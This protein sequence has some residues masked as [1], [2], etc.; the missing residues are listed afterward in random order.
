MTKDYK[1]VTSLQLTSKR[2]TVISDYDMI[3]RQMAKLTELN[4]GGNK[5]KSIEKLTDLKNLRTL[6]L[7]DNLI[8]EFNNLNLPLLQYLIV[9]RNQISTIN[10]LSS[11]KKLQ[12]LSLSGN[13]IT[14]ASLKDTTYLLVNL[15]YLNLSD[16]MIDRLEFLYGYPK[17]VEFNI[18]NNPIDKIG[19]NTFRE[20]VDLEVLQLRNI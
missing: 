8:T 7:S 19:A 18:S 6:N 5:I 12:Y 16:N 11:V 9:D 3:F 15:T 20:V 4:L 1:S 2:I 14:D 13:L 17:L 10:N